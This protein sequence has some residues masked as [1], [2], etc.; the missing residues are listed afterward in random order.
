MTSQ[1]EAI[2]LIKELLR[3]AGNEEL[4]ALIGERLPEMDSTF[5]S[6]LA[7]AAEAE[8]A[9]NPVLADRLASL[10]ETLLPLRT[11]I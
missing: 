7:Q 4:Q 11:L 2:A 9:R 1:Q 5:F 3:A 6:V 10:A 8:S